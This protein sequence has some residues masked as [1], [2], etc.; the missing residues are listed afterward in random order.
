MSSASPQPADELRVEETAPSLIAAPEL[1]YFSAGEQELQAGFRARRDRWLAPIVQPCL[2][3]GLSADFVSGAALAMLVPFGLALFFPLGGWGH[4]IAVASLSLHVLLDGLDGPVARAAGTAGP[5]GAFTDMCLD[6]T[7]YLVVTTLL[8]SAGLMHGAAATAYV[9]SYTLSVVMVVLLN[10]LNRP[11]NYVVRTK[12]VLYVLVALQQ[13][14]GTNV[15]TAAAGSFAAVHA[16]FAAVG[17]IA[18]RRALR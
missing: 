4:V 13:L 17:F 5:A 1:N 6:H 10:I 14:T 12:Y 7:G 3:T 2:Q 16:L 15:L 9:G 18:V 8:A 11:L